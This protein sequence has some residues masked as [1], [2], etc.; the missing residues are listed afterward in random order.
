M[1][2]LIDIAF[3]DDEAL[4][5]KILK[6]GLKHEIRDKIINPHFFE[7]A[8]EFLEYLKEG[9]S[10]P[11]IVVTDINMPEMDGFELLEKIK[12]DSPNLTVYMCSAYDRVD[13]KEKAEYLGASGFFTKPLRIDALKETIYEFAEH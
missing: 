2:T 11:K 1:S 12:G 10:V 6:A 4:F 3:I 7:S 5:L 13:F 8:L 9:N